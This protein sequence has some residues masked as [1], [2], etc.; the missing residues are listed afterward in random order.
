MI[1]KTSDIEILVDLAILGFDQFYVKTEEYD[2]LI[3]F[4][5]Y[6][7][8]IDIKVLCNDYICEIIEE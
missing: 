1:I 3:E 2:F 5:P 6:D 8:H 7:K 4:D